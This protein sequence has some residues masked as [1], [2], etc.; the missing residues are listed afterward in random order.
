MGD[1]IEA[2]D[3]LLEA[4]VVS[5]DLLDVKGIMAYILPRGDIDR[6]MRQFKLASCGAVDAGAIAT[7]QGIGSKQT[8]DR[9][10]INLGKHRIEVVPFAIV[11]D[12]YRDLLCRQ[13]AS[14]GRA[15]AMS[16]RTRQ[17][18]L[19]LERVKEIRLVGFYDIVQLGVLLLC[20]PLHQITSPFIHH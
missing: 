10:Q 7:Q 6:F 3:L 5:I 1:T 20:W 19:A 16:R 2:A 17:F 15:A 13:A 4:R 14:G 18:A 12:Q 8:T 9:G 11:D